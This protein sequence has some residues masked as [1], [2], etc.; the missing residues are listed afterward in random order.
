M[1][2]PLPE[3]PIITYI[4]GL[5]VMATDSH[6]VG[7][8]IVITVKD[9]HSLDS[10]C[11]AS[12][13]SPCLADGALRVMLDGEEALLG[14]GSVVLGEDVVVSAVNLPGPCRTFGFEQYWERKKLENALHGRRL[15]NEQ[16][17][18]GEWILGVSRWLLELSLGQSG[19]AV[20]QYVHADK[21]VEF[22][23]TY[24]SYPTL[25]PCIQY[26]VSYFLLIFSASKRN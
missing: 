13:L 19:H 10:S 21:K 22:T 3:V 5:A 8:S 17:T 1:T 11:P 16:Q 12:G 14:P 7:H 2:S 9:P 15:K 24:T 25:T 4:T 20:G 18:M 6:G 23:A 26:V